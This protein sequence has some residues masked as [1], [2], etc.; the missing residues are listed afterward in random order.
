MKIWYDLR[1]ILNLITD[2]IQDSLGYNEIGTAPLPRVCPG[3]VPLQFEACGKGITANLAGKD[4]E[5]SIKYGGHHFI[6]CTR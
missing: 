4:H 5:R 6:R 1:E 2:G 3:H